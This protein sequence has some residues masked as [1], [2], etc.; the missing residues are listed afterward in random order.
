MWSRDKKKLHNKDQW[1][2]LSRNPTK[3]IVGDLG[4]VKMEGW[5]MKS[6]YI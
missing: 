5:R 3:Y 6:Y 2:V 4:N 1:K